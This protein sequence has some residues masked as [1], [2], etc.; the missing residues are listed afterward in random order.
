LF[1]I[2]CLALSLFVAPAMLANAMLFCALL[3]YA[4]GGKHPARYVFAA[5]VACVGL[6]SAMATPYLLG[7]TLRYPHAGYFAWVASIGV[8]AAA[9]VARTRELTAARRS[10]AWVPPPPAPR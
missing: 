4:F 6:V 9:C 3:V 7:E 2:Q 5:V 8:F 1:G 10:V